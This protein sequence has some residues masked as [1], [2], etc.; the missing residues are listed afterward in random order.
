MEKQVATPNLGTVYFYEFWLDDQ[1]LA[2]DTDVGFIAESFAGANAQAIA[3]GQLLN[4]VPVHTVWAEMIA[5]DW[6][7][8]PESDQI[9]R[10]SPRGPNASLGEE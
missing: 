8:E 4:A 7:A 6:E 3:M 2:F 5:P 9:L 10:G 1:H